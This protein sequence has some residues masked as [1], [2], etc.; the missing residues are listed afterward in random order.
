[1]FLSK[2]EQEEFE[3]LE[4]EEEIK[5]NEKKIQEDTELYLKNY[6]LSQFSD[7]ENNPMN[8]RYSS[9]KYYKELEKEREKGFF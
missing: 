6:I 1:M 7:E 3:T 9:D 2:K 5:E 8:L 4:S